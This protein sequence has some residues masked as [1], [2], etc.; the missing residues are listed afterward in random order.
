MSEQI[1]DVG[2]RPIKDVSREIQ[3]A[4]AAGHA[5]QRDRGARVPRGICCKLELCTVFPFFSFFR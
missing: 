1:V 3:A 5:R 2:K 4:V